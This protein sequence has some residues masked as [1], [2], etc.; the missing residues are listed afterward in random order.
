MMKRKIPLLVRIERKEKSCLE[1]LPMHRDNSRSMD[2]MI[3]ER[4]FNTKHM[5]VTAIQVEMTAS[6]KS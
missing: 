2:S 3:Q 4:N 5:I 6:S 1:L